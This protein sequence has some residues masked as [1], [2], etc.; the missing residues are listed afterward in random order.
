[1]S[2]HACGMLAA[3]LAASSLR[4]LDLCTLTLALTH[5]HTHTH[6]LP[7]GLVGWPRKVGHAEWLGDGV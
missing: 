4:T 1:M 3:A 7:G 6:T 5:T 2:G